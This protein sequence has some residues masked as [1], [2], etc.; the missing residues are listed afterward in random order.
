[1]PLRLPPGGKWGPSEF[2]ALTTQVNDQGGRYQVCRPNAFY[3]YGWNTPVPNRIYVNHAHHT[4]AAS[5]VHRE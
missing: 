2:L 4:R 5:A 3:R 1:M